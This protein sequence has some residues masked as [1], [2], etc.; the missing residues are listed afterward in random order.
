MTNAQEVTPAMIEAAHLAVGRPVP[1]VEFRAQLADS[2][3]AAGGIEP[4][5]DAISGQI[6]ENLNLRRFALEYLSAT[7]EAA[8][9]EVWIARLQIEVAERERWADAADQ[10]ATYRQGC[11]DRWAAKGQTGAASEY[12]ARAASERQFAAHCR[13]E[14][15]AKRAVAADLATAVVR[16]MFTSSVEAA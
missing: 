9:H 15:A 5:Y 3:N 7:R 13:D 1:P 16:E 14:A 12:A 2:I 8:D 4:L 10:E 11:A 6:G